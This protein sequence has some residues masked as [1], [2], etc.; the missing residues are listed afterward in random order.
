VPKKKISERASSNFS[1]IQDFQTHTNNK[2]GLNIIKNE[3]LTKESF[4]EGYHFGR[5]WVGLDQALLSL[6]QNS[7]SSSYYIT[8]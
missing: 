3:Q 7:N 2:R 1:N 6:K 8:A 4:I 5:F